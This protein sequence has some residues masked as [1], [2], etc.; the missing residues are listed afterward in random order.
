MQ[1]AHGAVL[2][3]K[4]W[5]DGKKQLQDVQDISPNRLYSAAVEQKYQYLYLYNCMCLCLCP[6]YIVPVYIVW[7][8]LEWSGVELRKALGNNGDLITNPKQLATLCHP[9]NASNL[10]C[11]FC[12]SR[13]CRL[14]L[15]AGRLPDRVRN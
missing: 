11:L 15:N 14:A 9:P 12:Q 10:F 2:A 4:G 5:N 1:F 3:E 13:K 6:M 8:I 7:S